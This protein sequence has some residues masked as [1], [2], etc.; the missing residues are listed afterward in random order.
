MIIG[1][2]NSRTEAVIPITIQDSAGLAVTLDAVI[3]IGFSGYLTL[4]LARIITLQLSYSTT[5]T[6]A[7]GNNTQVNFD[8]YDATLVWD[9]QERDIL[10]LASEAHPLVGWGFSID[11]KTLAYHKTAEN[12]GALLEGDRSNPALGIVG[13]PSRR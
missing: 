10:V 1:Q 3:D 5:Q 4:P 6:Y 11:S 8:L 9:G 2:V 12:Y 7:L 13:L